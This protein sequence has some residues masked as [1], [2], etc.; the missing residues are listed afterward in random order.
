LV[1]LDNKKCTPESQ[2]RFVRR[3]DAMLRLRHP[4]VLRLLDHG[5]D[6]Y[7]FVVDEFA[8]SGTLTDNIQ[9]YSDDI[10]RALRVGRDLALGL[11]VAHK[12]G[13][14]HRDVSPANIH[15]LSIDHA[16]IGG[17]STV[18]LP[19]ATPITNIG[20]RLGSRPFTPPEYIDRDP[21][22]AFD[23]FSLGA[24]LHATLLGSLEP[25]PPY[26]M[27]RTYQPL[28][29]QHNRRLALIDAVLRP[30][31]ELD[32]ASR[33][34]SMREVVSTIDDLLVRLFGTH[35]AK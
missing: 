22:P 35:E 24:V 3:R 25:A 18:H 17:F 16:A 1:F 13:L 19:H 29:R 33:P 6:P 30:M 12:A 2:E 14:I 21:S 9:L 23:V 28:A 31:L 27:R 26:A 8:R 10:W 5:D 4:C 11:E 7:P 34:Q 20:E 32:A 15:L